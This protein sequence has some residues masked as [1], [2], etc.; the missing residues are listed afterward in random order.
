MKTRSFT[1]NPS[2]ILVE[3]LAALGVKYVFYNPGS[4]EARFYDALHENPEVDGILALHEGAVAG[5]AGGYTQVKNDPAVMVVHLGA[6]LAQSLGQMCNIWNARL[7]V[8]VI[9]HAS[10]TGSGTDRTGWGHHLSHNV[11]P[12]SISAPFVKAS[13]AVIRPDGIAHA[14]YRALLVAKTPPVGAVHLALYEGTLIPDELDVDIVEGSLPDVRA[15][16]P[17]DSDVEEIARGL[18]EAERPILYIGDGIWKSGAEAQLTAFAERFGIAITGGGNQWMRSVPANHKLHC[19]DTSALDPDYVIA[20][21]IRQMGSFSQFSKAQGLVA[22]GPDVENL[23]NF[24]GLDLA[25]LA[26][27]GR[28][29]ERLD[30]CLASTA[31]DSDRF[32]DRR[33]WVL[34]QAA[35]QQAKRKEEMQNVAPQES[36]VR[37]WVLADVMDKSLERLGGGLILMEQ[38][39][40][41][42]CLG[43]L[44]PAGNNLY[45]QPAGGSER[46]RCRRCHRRKTCRTR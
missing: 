37:P 15:G 20:M 22:V 35:A 38:S 18:T 16:Y 4:A 40:L 31:G 2:Q 7:P 39:V 30:E 41:M 25:V 23:K 33:N 45:L 6:G 8:V 29:L 14:M 28:T 10:D 44:Q 17:A 42:Q 34:E 26:D 9:T 12:T 3:Q 36:R 19:A 46:L 5:M 1:G 24:E 43:G 32:A 21:G 27:E 13:W 11:G